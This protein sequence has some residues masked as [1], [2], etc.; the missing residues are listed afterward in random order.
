MD[1]TEDR[2]WHLQTEVARLNRLV[3]HLYRTLEIAPPP[4]P[5]HGDFA[6]DVVA[7]VRAGNLIEAI[8]LQRTHTGQGLREAKSA[9]DGLAAQL[10]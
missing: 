10:H 6:A 3:E 1:S 4:E 8:K 2:V 7:A 9:V 5:G